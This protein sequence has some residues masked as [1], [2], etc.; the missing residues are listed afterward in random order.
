M[1]RLYETVKRLDAIITRKKLDTYKTRGLISVRTGFLLG[2]IGP[3][4]PDSDEK[5][6]KLRSAVQEILGEVV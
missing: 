5:L 3:E 4:T 1:T 6:G 2:N